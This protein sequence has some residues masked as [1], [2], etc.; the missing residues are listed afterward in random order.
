MILGNLSLPRRCIEVFDGLVAKILSVSWSKSEVVF[1]STL[2]LLVV[3]FLWC[4]V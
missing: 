2:V 4:K 1:M 3:H